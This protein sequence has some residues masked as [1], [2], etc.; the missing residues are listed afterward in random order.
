MSVSHRSPRE[1]KPQALTLTQGFFLLLDP[2]TVPAVPVQVLNW[3]LRRHLK[4]L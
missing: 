3:E 4:A 1:D 2:T